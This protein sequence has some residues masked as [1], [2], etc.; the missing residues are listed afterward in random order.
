MGYFIFDDTSCELG[1]SAVW[2][3]ARQSFVWL[4]ILSRKLFEKSVLG[5]ASTSIHKLQYTASAILIPFGEAGAVVLLVANNGV[6]EF[7]LDTGISFVKYSYNLPDTHRTNDAGLDSI[8]RI[9]FGVMEWEPSGLNGWVSR[10]N[11]NGTIETLIEKIGIP[12]TFVWPE[13]GSVIY[14]ADSYIQTMFH[15]EYSGVTS[16]RHELFSLSN[17]ATPD[18][19]AIENGFLYNAEWG[20]WRVTKR[21]L[22]DGKLVADFKLPVPQPTSCAVA[23]NKI[24]VT[25]AS[26]GLTDIEMKQFPCSGKTF[27][28]SLDEFEIGA[29]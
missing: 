23:G 16:S 24:L 4:D 17:G 19:S 27:L 13:D 8:G 11:L 21:R 18:G 29:V 14:F 7:N 3:E 25:T 5:S 10:I 6:Y 20:G 26:V 2:I 9:V 15:A 22:H 1:E 28:V 12:N